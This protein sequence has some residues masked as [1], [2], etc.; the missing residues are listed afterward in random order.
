M[1]AENRGFIDI[2]VN[3]TPGSSGAAF[4]RQAIVSNTQSHDLVV[5]QPIVHAQ[6]QR[7]TEDAA[8]RERISQDRD[9]Y[10]P[11]YADYMA[12]TDAYGNITGNGRR[13]VFMPVDNIYDEDRVIE[14][15]TFFLPVADYVCCPQGGCDPLDNEEPRAALL[16]GVC[17]VW[18]PLRNTKCRLG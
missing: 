14:F 6:G 18:H 12:N 7:Q 5:G 4:I 13:I 1:A 16:C 10:S 11:T 9:P 17:G 15:A 2:G 3:G 8:L